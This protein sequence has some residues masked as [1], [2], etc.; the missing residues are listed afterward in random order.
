[1][2]EI[3]KAGRGSIEGVEEIHINFVDALVNMDGSNDVG[4]H[5]LNIGKEDD[6]VYHTP[7]GEYEIQTVVLKEHQKMLMS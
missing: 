7:I 1:M 2:A 3:F 5:N 4:F 6:V